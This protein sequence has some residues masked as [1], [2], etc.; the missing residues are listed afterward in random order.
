[1][2]VDLAELVSDGGNGGDS[3][4]TPPPAKAEPFVI[5]KELQETIARLEESVKLTK[6]QLDDMLAA[7]QINEVLA[8]FNAFKASKGETF[9]E[10]AFFA[11][12][13]SKYNEMIKAG[14]TPEEAQE[15]ADRLYVMNP[16]AWV[17]IFDE[18]QKASAAATPDVTVPDVS[19]S[20]AMQSND[21]ELLKSPNRQNLGKSLITKGGNK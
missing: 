13:E 17:A 12:I 6:T 11:Y 2:A 4:S 3:G 18:V 14:A 1:M 21:E 5:P 20:D 15:T 9:D 8:K 7:R 16:A 10:A 19:N